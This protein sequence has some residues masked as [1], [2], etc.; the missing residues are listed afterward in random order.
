[1]QK[2]TFLSLVIAVS[3]ATA[4]GKVYAQSGY[5]VS[6][7]FHIK[8][9]G[10]WDYIFPDPDSKNLYVSHGSQVIVLNKQTGDSIGVIKDTKGVHGIA[11]VSALGKGYTS[12]GG[13]NT[14]TVFNT[15]TLQTITT[16]PVGQNPDAIFYDDYSKKIL[17]CN[18][19]SNDLTVID[20][21]ND[22]VVS[23]IPVGGKPETAVSNGAGKIFVNNEDKSEIEV[24]DINAMKLVNSWPIAPGTSP[25]GLSIDG[26]T[27]RLFAGCDNKLL[28]VI[29]AENGK[30]ITS[31]PIG[32]GCD[33]TAFDPG[34]KTVYSSNGDGTLTVIKEVNANKFV[35]KENVKTL[36]GA[37]TLGVDNTSHLIY[38]P[39]AD[40]GMPA[41][42]QKRPPMIPGSFKVLVVKP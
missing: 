6:Q 37:R 14:V 21:S 40:F 33:G 5:N 15:K 30:V 29:N 1:M 4:A 7:T 31:L 8:S 41:A 36:R 13:A 24:I 16:I 9:E 10:F 38:L 35:V 23:T 26:Q 28:M 11:V 2:T 20:P 18:G 12:N 19:R 25:S 42:G 3:I 32:D 27:K 17:T 34:I 22:K 39:T